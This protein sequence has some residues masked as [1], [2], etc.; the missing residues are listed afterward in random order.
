MSHMHGVRSCLKLP[1]ASRLEVWQTTDEAPRCHA[2]A[3]HR[4]GASN[5][6]LPLVSRI[7]LEASSGFSTTSGGTAGCVACRCLPIAPGA[8]RAI[9]TS[10]GSSDSTCACFS[11]DSASCCCVRSRT[12][13]WQSWEVTC[14]PTAR[15]ISSSMPSSGSSGGPGASAGNLS[16]KL[17]DAMLSGR[18]SVCCTATAG[19]HRRLCCE[20]APQA[21]RRTP[22]STAPVVGVNTLASRAARGFRTALAAPISRDGRRS[23][24][25]ILI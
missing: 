11:A 17:A 8:R 1:G 4:W 24:T 25:C 21:P 18:E 9:R 13:G 20:A 14:D 16:E 6:S 3:S 10:S 15:L 22:T 7:A 23:D 12:L 2:T 19:G 5:A